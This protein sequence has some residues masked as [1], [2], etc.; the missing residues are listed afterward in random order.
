MVTQISY[1]QGVGPPNLPVYVVVE[2]DTYIGPP[3]DH[4]NPK[5]VS[6]PPIKCGTKKQIPFK[7]AWALTI[8]K[9]QDLTLSKATIDIRKVKQQ[10]LTFTTIS[11]VKSLAGL[12]ISP[13]FSFERYAK[14]Q[15]G[16]YVAL[17]KQE[18]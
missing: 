17:R 11:C 4:I 8:H 13:F 1:T 15:N 9:S 7:M 16:A 18:E 3:W 5:K 10:G 12:C 14:M 2:L 6:I